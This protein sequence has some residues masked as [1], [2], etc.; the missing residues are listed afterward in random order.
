MRGC[1]RAAALLRA[2]ACRK[3]GGSGTRIAT[4]WEDHHTRPLAPLAKVKHNVHPGSGPRTQRESRGEL[5]RWCYCDSGR[6]E[7]TAF[8]F[9]GANGPLRSAPEAYRCVGV[10]KVCVNR[11]MVVYWPRKAATPKPVAPRN[12]HLQSSAGNSDPLRGA[13]RL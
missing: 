11:L 12:C 2:P 9:C 8:E 7:G 5:R 4:L 10:I 13:L 3:L 1:W 6:P